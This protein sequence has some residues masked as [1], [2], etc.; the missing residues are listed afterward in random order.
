MSRPCQNGD[1]QLSASKCGRNSA[2]IRHR[3]ALVRI[4][5]ADV[6][7]HPADQVGA[8][9]LAAVRQGLIRSLRDP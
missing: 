3:H 7:V 2:L 4:V 1:E 5:D 8:A 6:D 9:Y